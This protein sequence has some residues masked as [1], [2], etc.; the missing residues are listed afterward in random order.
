MKLD[1][2]SGSFSEGGA[3]PSLY[4]CDGRDISPALAWKNVPDGTKSFALI[5][6]DPDAP[7]GTWVHWVIYR[8]PGAERSL[9][10]SVPPKEAL[11][12]GARQG[13]ND[14]GRIGYGGPCPP[15]G[16]H[17]YFFRIYA[18]DIIPG[19]DPGA[20]KEELLAAMKGHV[21]AQGEL[22]GVYSRRR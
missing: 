7:V 6:D 12:N 14:F 21:L 4:T 11:D 5:C 19:L 18:L 10:E 15:G 22:M 3:I 16:S 8:I 1:L 17:R 9:K 13:R 2:S 20:T